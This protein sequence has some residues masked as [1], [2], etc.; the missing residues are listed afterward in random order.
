MLLPR[1][2]VSKIF[3][4][5]IDPEAIRVAN[6][7]GDRNKVGKNL[8]FSTSSL[9]KFETPFPLV[10]ANILFDALYSL[11][12]DLCR[13][14]EPGGKLILSGLLTTQKEDAE[15]AFIEGRPFKLYKEISEGEWLTVCLSREN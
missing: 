11:R 13:L 2:G 12:E 7:N 6:E 10:V 9:E 8:E 1:W 3:G 4:T 15:K 14:V 5:D